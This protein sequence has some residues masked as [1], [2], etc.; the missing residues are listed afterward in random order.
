MRSHR[1]AGF[2]DQLGLRGLVQKW[3]ANSDV[4]LAKPHL[5]IFQNALSKLQG[6]PD[7]AL[8]VGDSYEGDVVGARN[9]GMHALFLLRQGAS[10]PVKDAPIISTLREVLPYVHGSG[11]PLSAQRV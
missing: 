6:E 10:P 2:I 8:H 7:E 9:A 11:F 3:S 5:A 4:D 1:L